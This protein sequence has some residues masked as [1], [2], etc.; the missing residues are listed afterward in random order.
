[1]ADWLDGVER[2]PAG[3]DG[4]AQ[5]TA[6][7][8]VVWHTTEG[9]SW[10]AAVETLRKNNTEP[11]LLW[12]PKTGRIGQYFPANRAARALRNLDGGVQT[13][14]QGALQIE[15]LGFAE[16][17]FTD[18]PMVGLGRI[19]AWV[20]A[21]GVPDEW[22]AGRPLPYPES[23]GANG[24]RTVAA[25]ATPGHFGHSQ[26]PENAHG[27]PGAIDIDKITGGNDVALTDEDIDKIATRAAEKWQERFGLRLAQF[28]AGRPNTVFNEATVGAPPPQPGTAIVP[29]VLTWERKT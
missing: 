8:R 13:N 28:L 24:Q 16:D 18:G 5:M 15:V 4:G 9:L 7:R 27:D 20:R 19:M 23:Y 22:P 2:L 14:R 1:M 17:P 11:H 3:P 6:S 25:W 12:D 21:N 10:S 29:D 26:V